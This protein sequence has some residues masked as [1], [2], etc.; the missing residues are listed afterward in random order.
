VARPDAA[1]SVVQAATGAIRSLYDSIVNRDVPGVQAVLAPGAL[2]LTPESDGLLT[3]ADA[4]TGYL[5]D[6]L[7]ACEV[8]RL[9]STDLRVGATADGRNAWASDQLLID[10]GAP[11]PSLV[12]MTACLTCDAGRGRVDAA[13]CSTPLS[14]DAARRYIEDGRLLP[15]V[16][17]ADAVADDA[18]PLVEVLDACL[19]DPPRFVD[20]CSTADDTMAFGSAANEVLHGLEVREAWD[21]FVGYGPR[22]QRRGGVVAGMSE[23]G[24]LGWVATHVDISFDITRPYRFLIFYARTQTG[25]EMVSIHDSVSSDILPE[26]PAGGTATPR[27]SA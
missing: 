23:H 10:W 17:L 3:T 2:V 19:A 27:S 20:V 21:V 18:R 7:A 5:G 25:W 22:M 24:G 6:R 26:P 11:H 12:R 9:R 14:N 16:A 13:H 15:G 1:P 4:A 8:I